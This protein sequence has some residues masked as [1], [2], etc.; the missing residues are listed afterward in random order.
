MR[1]SQGCWKIFEQFVRLSEPSYGHAAMFNL[2]EDG[3]HVDEVE[4]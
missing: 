2:Q 1:F 4:M 3:M